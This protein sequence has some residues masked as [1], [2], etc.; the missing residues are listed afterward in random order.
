M[1]LRFLILLLVTVIAGWLRFTAT[2]FGLPDK[3]RPDEQYLTGAAFGLDPTWN[4]HFAIYPAGQMYLDRLVFLLHARLRGNPPDFWSALTVDSG[5]PAYLFGRRISAAFG[6]ATIPAVY[7][8]AVPFG[9]EAALAASTLMAA[10][11]LH[12]RESKYWTTDAGAIFWLTLCLAMVMRIVYRGGARDYLAAGLLAGIGTATKY[13]VGIVVIAIAVGHL[14]ARAREGRSIWTSLWDGRIY[15]AAL[16][17]AIAFTCVTPYFFLDWNRTVGDY[18]YQ[19]GFVLYG[20][21]NP[22]SSFGWR[23]LFLRAMPE[24]FGITMFALFTVSVAWMAARRW[25]GALSLLAFVLAA[26]SAM[27]RSHYVF[28]RYLLVPLPAMALFGGAFLADLA[29]LAAQRFDLR[30]GR[31][32]LGCA[33]LLLI[34]PSLIRDIE[35]N[36]LLLRDDSRTMA[37]A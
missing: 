14:E 16:A 23:W 26:C 8:A 27:T 11:T 24:S 20:L 21:P 25:P 2:S 37:R 12:M 28:Y 36:R 5:A 9:A 6:T 19:R 31:P 34:L 13:P 22:L 1:K 35:L 15:L 33:L 18:L 7:F 17:S 32:L 29:N 4:P 10:S 30:T 3:F